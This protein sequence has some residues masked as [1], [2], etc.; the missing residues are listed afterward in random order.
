[1]AKGPHDFQCVQ[2]FVLE[3]AIAL[4]WKESSYAELIERKK[5]KA[6]DTEGRLTRNHL[7]EGSALIA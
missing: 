3:M 7:F 6:S 5:S 2:T 4:T 1:M